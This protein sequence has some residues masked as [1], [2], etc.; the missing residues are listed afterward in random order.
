MANVNTDQYLQNNKQ[1]AG[2][3]PTYKVGKTQ[4]ARHSLAEFRRARARR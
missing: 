3:E 2:G 4:S 1:Y